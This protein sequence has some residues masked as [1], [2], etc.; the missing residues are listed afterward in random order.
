MSAPLVLVLI[1][2]GITVL[3]ALLIQEWRSHL[4]RADGAT[5]TDSPLPPISLVV[6][7]RDAAEELVPLLQD[8]NAQH[9][10]KSGSEVIVV[11]DNS[12][13]GTAGVVSSMR[14]N[15][16]EL[17]LVQL[18]GAQ[19]KKAALTAGFDAAQGVLV[20]C[21]DADVRCGP[22]RSARVAEFA[23]RTQADM[24]I[25]PV[26][27]NGGNGFWPWLQRMEQLALQ[28]ATL[29]SGLAG[30]PVLANGANMA[31]RKAAFTKVGG[32]RGD[33]WASG[34]DI[35]LLKRMRASGMRVMTLADPAIA[36]QVAPEPDA[37]TF[38]RQR[39]RWA[40]KMRAQWDVAGLFAMLAAIALPLFL[41]VGTWYVVLHTST[42]YLRTWT[43]LLAA[44]LCWMVP[45]I[46]LVRSTA[47]FFRTAPFNGDGRLPWV[48]GIAVALFLFI[49][50]A[51]VIAIVSIFVRPTWKG[52]RI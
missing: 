51:P 5:K 47:R 4:E 42:A 36:V 17:R 46:R 40:G 21:C 35:F 16:P 15:W 20:L 33:R 3:H 14:S 11:D 31:I 7:A 29:G 30:T 34:D 22:E 24:L 38:F 41:V 6:P 2:F 37:L 25:L 27:T 18:S 32:Y 45:I 52:R 50:Y 9:Y 48:P 44:W 28:G 43:L 49:I 12:T 19:G 26:Y 1:L 8:L 10:P 23:G 39:L 13:D